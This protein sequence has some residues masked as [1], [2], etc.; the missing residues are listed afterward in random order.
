MLL[1]TGMALAHVVPGAFLLSTPWKRVSYD[2][3]P[4]ETITNTLLLKYPALLNHVARK[5][6]AI[7]VWEYL[8]PRL[9]VVVS[10]GRDLSRY[11]LYTV[12]TLRRLPEAA[13]TPA[14]MLQR[15]TEC[16]FGAVCDW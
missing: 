14:I 5:A 8:A 1:V 4:R 15:G 2:V 10:M 12:Q 6:R 9:F 13:P 11:P 16:A 3:R 7:V